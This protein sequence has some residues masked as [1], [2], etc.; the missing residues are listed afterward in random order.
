MAKVR[1][2]GSHAKRRWCHYTTA[3]TLWNQHFLHNETVMQKKLDYS[4]FKL[5]YRL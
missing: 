3:I 5:L 2:F 4:Q 1:L